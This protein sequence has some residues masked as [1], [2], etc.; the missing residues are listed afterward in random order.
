MLDYQKSRLIQLFESET[1]ALKFI[2]EIIKMFLQNHGRNL[3]PHIRT[4]MNSLYRSIQS[5]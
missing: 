3:P 5:Y 1:D 4:K 2:G